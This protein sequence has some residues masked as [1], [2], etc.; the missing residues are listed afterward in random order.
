ML[1]TGDL[2]EG[3]NMAIPRYAYRDYVRLI[4]IL[5]ESLYV[6]NHSDVNILYSMISTYIFGGTTYASGLFSKPINESML[7]K[8]PPKHELLAM[9]L[10][11]PYKKYMYDMPF[12]DLPLEINSSYMWAECITKWRLLIGK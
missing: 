5:T 2:S 10:Q 3:N 12:E 11:Q 8:V 9:V 4:E 7:D 6:T 1:L